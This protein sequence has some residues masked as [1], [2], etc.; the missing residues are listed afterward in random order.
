MILVS[1]CHCH[2]L[3]ISHILFIDVSNKYGSYEFEENELWFLEKGEKEPTTVHFVHYSAFV[4]PLNP[5]MS[6]PTKGIPNKFIFIMPK[7]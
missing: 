6:E 2:Y 5:Q 7:T 3:C 1:N 4:F